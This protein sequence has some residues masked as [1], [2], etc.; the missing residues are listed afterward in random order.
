MGRVD[1]DFVDKIIDKQIAKFKD[2]KFR[3]DEIKKQVLKNK[4][5]ALQIEMKNGKVVSKRLDPKFKENRRKHLE[6]FLQKVAKK[7]KNINTTFFCNVNDWSCKHDH[8]YPIFVMSGFYGTYNFVIPDYLFLR[9]Y[10]QK[11]GRNKD[12]EPHDVI[13]EK[14]KGGDWLNKLPKCFFR[15]GTSKNRVILQMF[16]DHHLVDA[17]WS[18]DS[19]LSYDQMF[20]HKYVI[21]HYMRWDSVYFFLK[22][23]ILVFMYDGFGQYL[24]Y[25][26]FL[27]K[28]RHYVPFKTKEEF[29][30]KFTEMEDNPDAAKKIIKRSTEMVDTYFKLDF[31]IDYVGR[32]LLKYQKLLYNDKS[33][34]KCDNSN[35][36]PIP[37]SPKND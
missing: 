30:K 2:R 34:S 23:N 35:L 26:L 36:Q 1:W 37:D 18:R 22:T 8:K 10:S 28:N 32:L 19:F 29:E 3:I 4:E 17:K 12:E 15:A 21:S 27:E 16:K 5:S 20:D 13:A 7:Y 31:A 33:P 25:D 9:D 24:W 11:N 6:C 14:Y